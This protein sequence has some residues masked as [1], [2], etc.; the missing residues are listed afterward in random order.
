[1]V[2]MVVVV[3]GMN[4]NHHLRLRRIGNHET[5]DENQS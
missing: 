3:A 4:D 1:M 2:V 5:D